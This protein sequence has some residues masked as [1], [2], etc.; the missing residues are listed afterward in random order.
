MHDVRSSPPAFSFKPI[1]NAGK[2]LCLP[3]CAAAN[4]PVRQL[5]HLHVRFLTVPVDPG[6]DHAR[7]AEDH[8]AVAIVEL[9]FTDAADLIPPDLAAPLPDGLIQPVEE[10]HVAVGA[11]QH[12]A[13]LLVF[14]DK[15]KQIQQ[16]RLDLL[17]E[18]AVLVALGDGIQLLKQLGLDFFEHIKDVPVIQIEG[19][20]VHVRQVGQLLH[21]DLVDLLFLQQL[22]QR[23]GQQLFR[24]PD[25]SVFLFQL[26]SHGSPCFLNSF[27]ICVG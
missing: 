16:D 2:L 25:P 21:G 9:L 3:V 22:R 7:A 11:E 4:H 18:L 23:L 27:S 6:A 5:R 1:E 26:F 12:A 8:K 20:P 15:V 13:H 17:R 24:P 10:I 19:A 14:T